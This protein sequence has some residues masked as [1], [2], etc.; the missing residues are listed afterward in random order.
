MTIVF[1]NRARASPAPTAMLCG[2][3]IGAV[4]LIFVEILSVAEVVYQS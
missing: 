1:G 4:G 3:E 2:Y